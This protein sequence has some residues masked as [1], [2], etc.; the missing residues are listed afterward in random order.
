MQ[1][2]HRVLIVATTA[3]EGGLHHRGGRRQRHVHDRLLRPDRGGG[4]STALVKRRLHRHRVGIVV[5]DVLHQ[6]IDTVPGLGEVAVGNVLGGVG[7]HHDHDLV[8]RL[9][10]QHVQPHA[11]VGGDHVHQAEASCTKQTTKVL[12][13]VHDD[14]EDDD[15][16]YR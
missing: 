14:L 7:R 13:T 5:V 11:N 12:P 4:R 15:N 2:S 9:L 1:M 16:T 3:H 10:D 6:V 8:L